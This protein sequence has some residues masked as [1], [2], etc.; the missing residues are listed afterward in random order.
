MDQ[1]LSFD[2]LSQEDKDYLSSKL[3]LEN[4]FTL[5]KALTFY[6]DADNYFAVAIIGDPP[7]GEIAYDISEINFV[8]DETNELIETKN[9]HGK[10]ARDALNLVFDDEHL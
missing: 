10:N 6:A 5:T 1:E 9:V 3:T 2:N 7:C 4:F 8:N